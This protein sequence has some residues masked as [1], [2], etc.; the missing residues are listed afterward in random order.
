MINDIPVLIPSEVE[1]GQEWRPLIRQCVS[2]HMLSGD[3]PSAAPAKII[4]TGGAHNQLWMNLIYSPADYRNNMTL[5]IVTL[6]RERDVPC[7]VH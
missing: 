2:A 1:V 5:T 7:S 4:V 3:K 6:D